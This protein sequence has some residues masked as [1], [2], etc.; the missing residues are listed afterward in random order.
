MLFYGILVLKCSIYS[1]ISKRV[2][3]VSMNLMKL[4]NKS[5]LNH[6]ICSLMNKFYNKH[7]NAIQMVLNFMLGFYRDHMQK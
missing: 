3:L 5:A 4:I 6:M 2:K 1:T 7:V